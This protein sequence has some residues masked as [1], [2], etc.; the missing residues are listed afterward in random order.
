MDKI[1]ILMSREA[2][3]SWAK[4]HPLGSRVAVTIEG[5][6]LDGEVSGFAAYHGQF[7]VRI[8]LARPRVE[9]AEKGAL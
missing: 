4:A 8:R 2:Y 9:L 1:S 3:E 6:V 7:E 5:Q